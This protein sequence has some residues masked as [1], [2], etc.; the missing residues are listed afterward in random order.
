MNK[1]TLKKTEPILVSFANSFHSFEGS[2]LDSFVPN[3]W[4][5]GKRRGRVLGMSGRTVLSFG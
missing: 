4:S 1:R 5:L 3:R 2:Q